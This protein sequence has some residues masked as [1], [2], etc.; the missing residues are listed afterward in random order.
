V[1]A[2]VLTSGIMYE[3]VRADVALVLAGSVRDDGPL[4]EVITDMLAAQDAMRRVIRDG[5]GFALCVA[6][7]LHA[8]ATGNLLPA[9]VPMVCVDINPSIPTKLADRGTFQTIGVVTDVEPF[10]R[11][12]AAELGPGA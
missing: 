9:S 7:A 11:S 10:L 8:I 5:V 2:G 1:A 6:T 3:C 12:L 4:P